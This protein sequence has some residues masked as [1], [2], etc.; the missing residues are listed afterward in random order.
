MHASTFLAA[1]DNGTYTANLG[2]VTLN[3]A[4]YDTLATIAPDVDAHGYYSGGKPVAHTET[5]QI[6]IDDSNPENIVYDTQYIAYTDL[7][8]YL[9]GWDH[10]IIN[11]V[12]SAS[13]NLGLQFEVNRL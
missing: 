13:F 8:I 3:K 1:H 11:E 10:A 5:S 4:K 6:V 2:T 12:I 9:E 7:T